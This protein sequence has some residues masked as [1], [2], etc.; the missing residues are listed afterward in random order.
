SRRRSP[1][2]PP[3]ANPAR[4]R[5]R[6]LLRAHAQSPPRSRR[7]RPSRSPSALP[8]HS[9]SSTRCPPH[10]DDVRG[11]SVILGDDG[12]ITPASG[13][14]KPASPLHVAHQTLIAAEVEIADVRTV[15]EI[16]HK[17]RS[18][19]DQ[20]GVLGFRDNHHHFVTAPNSLRSTVQRNRDQVVETLRGLL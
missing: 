6:R 16:V 4:A 19:A 14:R 8:T 13:R 3:T 10:P 15:E 17:G 12:S 2:P 18:I 9:M 5:R 7:P 11:L 20:P 1:R